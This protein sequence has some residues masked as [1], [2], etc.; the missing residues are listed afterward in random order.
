MNEV[1]GKLL[2][3]WQAREGDVDSGWLSNLTT[4]FESVHI[5]VTFYPG[6]GSAAVNM[7]IVNPAGGTSYGWL[8]RNVC[9]AVEIQYP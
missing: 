1:T 6:D 9:H 3:T 2:A 7:Q 4:S 5:V 8:T